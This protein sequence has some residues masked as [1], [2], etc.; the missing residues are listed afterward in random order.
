MFTGEHA[1]PNS[2]HIPDG[3]EANS[4]PLSHKG[5]GKKDRAAM[6]ARSPPNL[7]ARLPLFDAGFSQLRKEFETIFWRI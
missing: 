4:F 2:N 1:T 3:I 5:R 6:A 7:C